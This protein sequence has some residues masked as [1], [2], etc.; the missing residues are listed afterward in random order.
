MGS[1][2]TVAGD[3]VKF[4]WDPV[5]F[6]NE[7]DVVFVERKVSKE[8]HGHLNKWSLVILVT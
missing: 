3:K 5:L 6:S 2:H 1:T 8:I 4:H 7:E